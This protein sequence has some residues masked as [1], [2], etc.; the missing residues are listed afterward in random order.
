[1]KF[2]VLWGI[3]MS[4]PGFHHAPQHL[5]CRSLSGAG[6]LRWNDY[7]RPEEFNFAS[8][9]LDHWTQMEKVRR[10]L[11][12]VWEQDSPPSPNR[13]RGTELKGLLTK[14]TIFMGKAYVWGFSSQPGHFLYSLSPSGFI[15]E[16]GIISFK[17]QDSRWKYLVLSQVIMT[18]CQVLITGQQVDVGLNSHLQL[19]R[20]WV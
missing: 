11:C 3:H 6:T 9:V 20:L 10:P 16:R 5:R 1:M 19:M 17:K 4:F 7:D 12:C 13:K 15:C 14:S 8:D 2:R 18:K